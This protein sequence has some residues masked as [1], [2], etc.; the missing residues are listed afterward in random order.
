M[1][2]NRTFD[3]VNLNGVWQHLGPTQRVEA[4]RN[5][6]ALTAPGGRMIVSV[7][8]GPGAPDRPCFQAPAE[9]TIECAAAHGFALDFEED[10][11]SIQPANRAA[12][13]TWTWLAFSRAI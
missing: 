13:V 10:R 4:M 3:L 6:A 5:I 8:H 11:E 1:R 2:R 12:G 9:T 7:R